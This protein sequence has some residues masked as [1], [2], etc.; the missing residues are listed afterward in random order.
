MN[1]LIRNYIEISN[2][3]GTKVMSL[4]IWKNLDI[5][6]HLVQCVWRSENVGIFQVYRDI[7]LFWFEVEIV[8]SYVL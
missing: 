6:T 7:K 5:F 2:E 1:L 4:Y 3:V 8:C